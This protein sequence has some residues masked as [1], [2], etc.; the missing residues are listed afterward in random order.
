MY[1]SPDEQ[2]YEEF[3][4]GEDDVPEDEAYEDE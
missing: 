4:P 1:E 3:D 2:L